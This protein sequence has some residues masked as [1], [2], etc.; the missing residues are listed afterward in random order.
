MFSC[1]P[2]T[3]G[4]YPIGSS[5]YDEDDS[6][7]YI[8]IKNPGSMAFFCIDPH[9]IYKNNSNAA[10]PLE[11]TINSL[12]KKKSNSST[13]KNNLINRSSKKKSNSK[14]PKKI[15]NSSNKKKNTNI[16]ANLDIDVLI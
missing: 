7:I 16:F 6:L 8:E 9:P 4:N 15:P 2:K 1:F 11:K 3:N 5:F 13:S 10:H 12:L 14:S